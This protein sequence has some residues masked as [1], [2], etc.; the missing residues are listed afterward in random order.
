LRGNTD[1]RWRALTAAA[2]ILV[3]GGCSHPTQR[4]VL[5]I[6]TC[7]VSDDNGTRPVACDQAHTHKVIAVAARPEECPRDTDMYS[8]PAD[9]D[10]GT[11][12]E[13]FRADA[14]RR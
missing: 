4:D 3:L 7:V 10:D 6:G 2:L 13:C 11:T 1:D 8:Q 14:T 12:T 9:P 5:A